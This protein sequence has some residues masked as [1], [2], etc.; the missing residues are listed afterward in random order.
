MRA[1]ALPK[2][3]RASCRPNSPNG[4]RSRR[5]RA[6]SLNEPPCP[7]DL[8]AAAARLSVVPAPVRAEPH[9]R[10][11]TVR[12]GSLA[13]AKRIPVDPSRGE[14]PAQQHQTT[15]AGKRQRPDEIDID[16]GAAQDFEPGPLV[17]GN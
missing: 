3:P 8:G 17:D 11:D 5:V 15:G 13:Y 1:G 16:P 6:P 10:R 12:P 7:P 4:F 2:R 9:A 14:Q